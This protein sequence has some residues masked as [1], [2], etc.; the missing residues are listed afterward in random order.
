[1]TL[2]QALHFVLSFEWLRLPKDGAWLQF[3]A[4]GDDLNA[5]DLYKWRRLQRS[6]AV[7]CGALHLTRLL[8]RKC[9]STVAHHSMLVSL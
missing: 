5:A 8:N 1:M 4:R 2:K 6:F 3:G 9:L 7:A